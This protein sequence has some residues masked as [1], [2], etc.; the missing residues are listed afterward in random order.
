LTTRLT[1]TDNASMTRTIG[2]W[3]VIRSETKVSFGEPPQPHP[4]WFRGHLRASGFPYT[5]TLEGA[6]ER[7]RYLLKSA[8]VTARG[9]EPVT[10]LTLRQVP[11]DRLFHALV[12][13]MTTARGGGAYGLPGLGIL[14]EGSQEIRRRG[15]SDDGVLQAVASLYRMA[16]MRGEPPV[17]TVMSEMGLSRATAGRW[18][19]RARER[20]FLGPAEPGKAGEGVTRKGGKRDGVR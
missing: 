9:G 5:V 14:S 13:S 15:P 17:R 2:K 3:R 11:L 7:G 18:I 12:T 16:V 10:A 19:D 6:L 4:V 8:S 20:Q 1:V